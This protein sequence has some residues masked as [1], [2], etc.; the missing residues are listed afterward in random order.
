VD[1]LVY[2]VSN[3]EMLRS[4]YAID[5]DP[6]ETEMFQ[7]GFCQAF[8]FRSVSLDGSHFPCLTK[9]VHLASGAWDGSSDLPD[10]ACGRLCRL[11]EV[12]GVGVV[13]LGSVGG[14][15]MYVCAMVP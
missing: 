3:A 15:G 4:R 6:A 8:C 10:P 14:L 9:K 2:I 11:S 7:A 12:W 5:L 1:I 13:V